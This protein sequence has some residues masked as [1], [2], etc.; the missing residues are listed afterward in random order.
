MSAELK[1]SF[2]YFQRQISHKQEQRRTQ[3]RPID[4]IAKL[5][6]YQKLSITA[7]AKFDASAAQLHTAGNL[8]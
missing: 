3:K 8:I 6:Y 7:I 5:L 1:R 4:Y 2:I